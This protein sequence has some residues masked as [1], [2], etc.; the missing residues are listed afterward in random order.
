MGEEK[1]VLQLGG[2]GGLLAGIALLIFLILIGLTGG[3]GNTEALLGKFQEF[4][5]AYV[6]VPG[7]GMIAF[8]LSVPLFLALRRASRIAGP[9]TALL[10]GFLG[11][12]GALFTAASWAITMAGLSVLSDLWAVAA[13]PQK[14]TILIVAQAVELG[15]THTLT[16]FGV[17]LIG[18]AFASF[19]WALN[20]RPDV[21]KGYGWASVVLGLLVAVSMFIALGLNETGLEGPF[22]GIGLFVTIALFLLLGWK[23]YTLS[24]SA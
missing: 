14:E 10:G 13:A 5:R 15:I 20:A 3:A 16:A 1:S 23:V 17:L 18:L 12:S 21:S 19:G 9:A 4:G 11:V 6:L 24:R 7:L 8:L 2:V 22:V